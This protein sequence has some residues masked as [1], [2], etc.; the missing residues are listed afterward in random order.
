[1]RVLL[2]GRSNRPLE[3]IARL[4]GLVCGR[5]DASVALCIEKACSSLGPIGRRLRTSDTISVKGIV[6]ESASYSD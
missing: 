2:L 4:H 6:H 3:D 5:L 1:M